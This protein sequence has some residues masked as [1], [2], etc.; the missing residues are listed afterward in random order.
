MHIHQ[1]EYK[2]KCKKHIV[3]V[4]V[5]TV[6]AVAEVVADPVV[7]TSAVTSLHANNT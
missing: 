4:V 3:A 7:V 6:T 5:V 2:K 1:I